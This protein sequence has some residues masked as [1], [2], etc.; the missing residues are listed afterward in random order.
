MTDIYTVKVKDPRTGIMV[1]MSIDANEYPDQQTAEKEIRAWVTK[2]P[3]QALPVINQ[4]V[5]DLEA[6]GRGHL[7]EKRNWLQDM[8]AAIT[9]ETVS[10][11]RGAEQMLQ[12]VTGFEDRVGELSTR[13]SRDRDAYRQ[14]WE[15][16]GGNQFS[17][18]F[19]EL[20]PD[21]LFY[22]GMRPGRGLLPVVKTMGFGA[23]RGA[24]SGA[25]RAVTGDD[26]RTANA[27]VSG[28][29]GAVGGAIPG[30]GAQATSAYRGG[31]KAASG[32]WDRF[33]SAFGEKGAHSG[34]WQAN[35]VASN[36]M[37]TGDPFLASVGK[38]AHRNIRGIV[39]EMNAG[40]RLRAANSMVNDSYAATL[41]KMGPGEASYGATRE[42]IAQLD[43]LSDTGVIKELGEA[44]G[45]RIV[46]VRNA[47]ET[48]EDVQ[49]A[50]PA[51]IKAALNALMSPSKAQ[52]EYDAILRAIES[53]ASPATKRRLW[54]K[55]YT[56]VA[57]AGPVMAGAEGADALTQDR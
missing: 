15:G 6:S 9:R 8:G 45:G 43:H 38:E 49:A 34:L 56:D 20:V 52:K 44:A 30:T 23:L 17:K 25:T 31:Q 50:G 27:L 16:A 24:A 36:L 32:L 29:G 35:R 37:N 46:R 57:T 14:L 55:F 54:Q 2:N 5:Q 22:L 10:R 28:I 7:L 1:P 12:G 33:T 40:S 26:D 18:F 4:R 41:G 13:E 11:V 19:G 53:S 42:F 21:S 48:L 3:E 39:R 51:Q 47:L